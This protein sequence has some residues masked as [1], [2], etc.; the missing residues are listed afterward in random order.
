MRL[1]GTEQIGRLAVMVGHY[2]EIFPVNYRLDD[3]V[4]VY[5]TRLGTKL[6]DAHHQNIGFEV[7]HLDPV[8]RTGWSVLI[9]GMAEDIAARA[10]DAV[11]RRT[12][13][14]DVQSWT[15]D[16]GWLVRIIPAYVTGRRIVPADLGWVS[17][18]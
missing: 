2:P 18:A 14:L 13:S 15:D 17:P 11:T 8:T 1:L 9:R 4:V 10:P 12:Q 3:F 16:D 6:S 7:D 5:R